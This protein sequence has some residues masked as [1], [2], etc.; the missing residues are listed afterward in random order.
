MIEKNNKG[1]LSGSLDPAVQ[2]ALGN[3]SKRQAERSLS[4]GERK[5]LL[6]EKAKA[7]ARKGRRALYDLPELL[8]DEVKDLG[9]KYGTSA[10]QIAM[11]ALWLFLQAEKG[12]KVSGYECKVD[13][14]EFRVLAKKNPKFEYV[15]YLPDLK[16]Y[17][18]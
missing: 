1:F 14:R 10:S 6:R 5:R 17:G 7:E 8:I 11:L 13:V 4:R 15:I 16:Y 3:G 9:A 2:A 18:E 12:D